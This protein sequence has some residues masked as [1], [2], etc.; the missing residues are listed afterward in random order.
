MKRILHLLIR[1]KICES[2]S[3]AVWINPMYRIKPSRL[4]IA[5]YLV[6]GGKLNQRVLISG[7]Q[8]LQMTKNQ[9]NLKRSSRVWLCLS[10]CDL[11]LRNV[12]R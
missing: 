2:L 3:A 8:G 6:L 4:Q 1:Q 11:N 7:S 9:R 10:G 5:V 12:R